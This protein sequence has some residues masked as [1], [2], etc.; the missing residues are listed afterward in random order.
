MDVRHV[1]RLSDR[2]WSHS[3]AAFSN[4]LLMFAEDGKS[5]A[6]PHQLLPGS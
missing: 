5:S 6:S 4:H 2:K 1:E 3:K